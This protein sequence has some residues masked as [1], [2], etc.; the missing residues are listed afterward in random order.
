MS[1]KNS[2][3]LS[4]LQYFAKLMGTKNI[5]LG[6]FCKSSVYKLREPEQTI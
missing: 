1:V 6:G 2:K 3:I 4:F 5:G